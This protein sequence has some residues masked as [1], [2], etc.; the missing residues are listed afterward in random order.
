MKTSRNILIAVLVVLFYTN[1]FAQL[2]AYPDTTRIKDTIIS[3]SFIF[4]EI[5]AEFPGGDSKMMKYLTENFTSKVAIS[6]DDITKFRSPAVKWTV[7]ET[8][9]VTDVKIVRS[10]NF[11]SV[12][13]L[14]IDV[15]TKMP[16]WK[17]AEM[18]NK[19]VK[20]VFT[21][22]IQICFK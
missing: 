9:K 20:Q 15:V 11:L 7:D 22:P 2:K 1:S 12:D 19:K 18:D 6:K 3:E 21:I 8:G 13:N 10:S 16:L 4:P 14:L 5:F 17:P